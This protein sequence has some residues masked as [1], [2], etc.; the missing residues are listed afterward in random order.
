MSAGQVL[1]NLTSRLKTAISII[2]NV[3]VARL[4]LLLSRV[5]RNLHN[6]N[7]KVFTEAEEAQLQNVIHLSSAELNNLLEVCAFIYEQA[8]YYSV[9]VSSLGVQLDKTGLASDR[10][11][12]FQ[13]VWQEEAEAL[14]IKLRTKSVAP[15]EL[16]GVGWRLHLHLSQKGLARIKAPTAIFEM[17]ISDNHHDSIADIKKDE[18]MIL[19]FDKSQ[20]QQFYLMLEQI[21]DQLDILG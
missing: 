2:N 13:K 10:I 9:S 3:N 20:L 8:A 1:F 21:Q 6:K 15:H 11:Q 19:E 12:A 16:E 18:K 7:E 4:P 14:I 5:I 17:S